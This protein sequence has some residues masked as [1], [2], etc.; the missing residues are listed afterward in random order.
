MTDKP[1]LISEEQ[2]KKD[3]AHTAL[4]RKTNNWLR[5]ERDRA[6]NRLPNEFRPTGRQN[7]DHFNYND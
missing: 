3:R 5:E 6:I 7:Y 1:K 4:R 2:T